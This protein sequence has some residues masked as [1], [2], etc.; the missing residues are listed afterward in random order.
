MGLCA[1]S[2][3]MNV[4]G[5]LPSHFCTNGHAAS[6]DPEVPSIS[7]SGRCYYRDSSAYQT[8]CSAS[9]AGKKRLCICS[10]PC[11]AGYYGTSGMCRKCPPRSLTAERVGMSLQASS[12][13]LS[14]SDPGSEG[15]LIDGDTLSSS[16]PSAPHTDVSSCS[17]NVYVE[18]DLGRSVWIDRI[19]RWLYYGDVRQYCNQKAAV[20]SS[21]AF[22]GEVHVIRIP[23][24]H[25]KFHTRDYFCIRSAARVT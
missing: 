17:T 11:H 12:V 3:S 19:V 23:I 7:A 22:S 18:L 16:Y 1:E 20:S 8:D 14:F 5:V 24:L 2:A 10:S 9:Y 6:P 21:G 13:S 4:S 25:V 15:F